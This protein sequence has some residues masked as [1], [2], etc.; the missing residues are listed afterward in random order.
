M[1]NNNTYDMYSFNSPQNK[2]KQK[3]IFNPPPIILQIY[4]NL[5]L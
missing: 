5:K 1:Y 3:I 2:F 4:N